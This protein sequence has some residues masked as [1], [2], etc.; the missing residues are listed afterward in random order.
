MSIDSFIHIQLEKNKEE[1]ILCTYGQL[2]IFSK[3]PTLFHCHHDY[4]LLKISDF[5][6]FLQ[7]HVEV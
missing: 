4:Q 6:T 1:I 5:W 2:H 7:C 3:L